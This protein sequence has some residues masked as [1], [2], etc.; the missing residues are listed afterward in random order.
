MLR[1]PDPTIFVAACSTQHQLTRQVRFLREENRI[2]RSKLPERISTT[3]AERRRL[4]RFGVP[5]GDAIKGLISIVKPETF[6]KWLRN[7]PGTR[8]GMRGRPRKPE[9]HRALVV[10][11]GREMACGST[12]VRGELLKL[13]ITNVSRTTIRRIL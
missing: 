11:I 2:L 13:G 6:A 7:G 10:Q 12:R 5:L 3:P 1:F 9:E 4:L 8:S